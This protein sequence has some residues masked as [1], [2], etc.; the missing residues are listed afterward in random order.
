MKF[1]PG[2]NLKALKILIPRAQMALK[3]VAYLTPCL[4]GEF[5]KDTFSM[6]FKGSWP[7]LTLQI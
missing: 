3:L 4:H 1:Y 7:C 2:T 6:K 5:L